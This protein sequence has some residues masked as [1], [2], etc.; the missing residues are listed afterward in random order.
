M[1]NKLL[2]LLLIMLFVSFGCK[3]QTTENCI[4]AKI[5]RVTCTGAVIQALSNNSIGE[6]DW[7]DIYDNNHYDNVFNASN[8]C[9][10]PSEYKVG[11]VIYITVAKPV[12]NECVHCA[13]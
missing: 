13:L 8:S 11:D 3:K 4:K 10:I 12:T 6:D 7:I 9:K 1:T 5:I 2:S